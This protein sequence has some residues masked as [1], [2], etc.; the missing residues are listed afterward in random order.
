M[1][2]D[3]FFTSFEKRKGKTRTRLK[4]SWTR[5]AHNEQF[6][7]S[8]GFT[9]IHCRAYVN[10]DEILSGVQNRNHCPYC[11]WS[12]HVDLFE[13]GDR[14]AACKAPMRPIGLSLKKTSKKYGC[15]N[16]ELMIVHLCSDCGSVSINRIAADD[17]AH[18]LFDIY[19]QF[20]QSNKQTLNDLKEDG[21]SPLGE[22]DANLVASRLFGQSIFTT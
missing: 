21:I 6:Q 12:K 5:L 20:C 19:T 2:K 3:D 4:T 8:Y 17:D 22:E 15:Q 1:N 10:S 16:G 9:C 18:G 14:L 13:S 7:R 11:L